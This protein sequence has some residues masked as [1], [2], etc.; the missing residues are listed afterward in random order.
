MTNP[1]TAYVLALD[2]SRTVL[3]AT[4]VRIESTLRCIPKRLF[5]TGQRSNTLSD[6]ARKHLVPTTTGVEWLRMLLFLIVWAVLVTC[7][8]AACE[9]HVSWVKVSY[10]HC[11][12]S[13]PCCFALAPT[14]A[15]SQLC[16]QR[17]KA[18]STAM[19]I[20]TR[21]NTACKK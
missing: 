2:C 11:L 12:P 8:Q 19:N 17:R 18:V 13:E 6:C 10:F 9:N 7:G 3:A 5:A 14:T 4:V 16:M 1:T 20:S 21:R 15:R